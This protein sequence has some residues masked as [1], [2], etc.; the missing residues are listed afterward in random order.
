MGGR[1]NALRLRLLRE[2]RKYIVGLRLPWTAKSLEVK[3]SLPA[4][5]GAI[6]VKNVEVLRKMVKSSLILANA[7]TSRRAVYV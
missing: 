1:Y 4:G 5:N 6:H 2:Q 3:I 7:S